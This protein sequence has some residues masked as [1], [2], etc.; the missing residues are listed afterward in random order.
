MGYPFR[1]CLDDV[2]FGAPDDEAA[3]SIS[4]ERAFGH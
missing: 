1:G 2:R 4:F 3:L